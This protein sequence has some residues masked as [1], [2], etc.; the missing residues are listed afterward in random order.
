MGY[1][2]DYDFSENSPEVI[3]AIEQISGYGDSDDGQYWGV[4]WYDALKDVKEISKD[5][6]DEL[7]K[8]E[9]VGEDHG[10]YWQF[11]A[12]NGLTKYLKGKV[13]FEDF[14]TSMLQDG[15]IYK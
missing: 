7:I 5:F 1:N 10:D 12:K 15:G 3:A 4:K 6:P 9:G 2:T 13:V 8:L 14:T 11:W